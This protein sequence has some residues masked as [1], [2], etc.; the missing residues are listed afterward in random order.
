MSKPTVPVLPLDVI[1]NII[2]IL[3][4]DDTKSLPYVKAFSLT[5]QSFLPLCRKHMFS[6]ISIHIGD[7]FLNDEVRFLL[8]IARYVRR[9]NILIDHRYCKSECSF[10]QVSRQLTGLKSITIWCSSQWGSSMFW[11]DISS[12]ARCSLLSLIHLPTLTH[13]DLKQIHDFP[14]SALITCTNLKHLAVNGHLIADENDDALSSVSHKPI[15]LEVFETTVT[16]TV[17]K[18][19]ASKCSDGRPVLDFTLLKK[20]LL[21]FKQH[22]TDQTGQIL[23]GTQ[24]LRDI[25]LTFLIGFG[26]MAIA[27]MVTPSLQTLKRLHLTFKGWSFTD[28]VSDLCD[29]LNKISGKNRLECIEIES[30]YLSL[31]MCGLEEVFLSSGWLMLKRVSLTVTIHVLEENS[32]STRI[33]ES[34]LQERLPGLMSSKNFDFL[35]T[36]QEE[37]KW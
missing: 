11:K 29:E 1:D 18:L 4:N 36:V 21:V 17:L 7:F 27:E 15:Q 5:C 23:S 10:D 35:F 22:G 2:D 3:F 33:I 31:E 13:L 14:I 32:P 9:L 6:S 8:D 20:V 34:A 16:L 26:R 30:D 19:L 37:T 24:Q 12:S 25:S 28:P